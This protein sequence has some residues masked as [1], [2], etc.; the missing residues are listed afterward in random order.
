MTLDSE[1]LNQ[2]FAHRVEVLLRGHLP[3]TEVRVPQITLEEWS[4]Y[5]E[6]LGRQESNDPKDLARLFIQSLKKD[7]VIVSRV[8]Y[9]VLNFMREQANSNLDTQ[10]SLRNDLLTLLQP[11]E[12]L[13]YLLDLA[14]G[15]GQLAVTQEMIRLQREMAYF[16]AQNDLAI[17]IAKG[18]SMQFI[19]FQSALRQRATPNNPM[20]ESR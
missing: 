3:M 1:R 19:R 11:D 15:E 12:G 6:S 7:D 5:G 18:K 20:R 13:R 17:E 16:G 10:N 8:G 9:L 2:P 14:A 4:L